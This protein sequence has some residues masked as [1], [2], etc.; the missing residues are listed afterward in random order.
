[1]TPSEGGLAT[2]LGFLL[3]EATVELPGRFFIAIGAF[4]RVKKI[5]IIK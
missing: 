4:L 1:L 3:K 2:S 5:F